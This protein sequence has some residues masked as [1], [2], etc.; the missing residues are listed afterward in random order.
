LHFT[1][2]NTRFQVPMEKLQAPIQQGG[3]GRCFEPALSR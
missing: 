3:L 2:L 1:L